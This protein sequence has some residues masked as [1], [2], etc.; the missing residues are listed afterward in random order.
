MN[1]AFTYLRQPLHLSTIGHSL[2]L[3]QQFCFSFRY[4]FLHP[5][6]II[7]ISIQTCCYPLIFSKTNKFSLN[8]SSTSLSIHFFSPSLHGKIL[9]KSDLFLAPTS[10]LVSLKCIP[11]KFISPSLGWNLRS[12]LLSFIKVTKSVHFAKSNAQF[13]FS[14][15]L[16]QSEALRSWWLSPIWNFLHLAS[17][18][19]HSLISL[20]TRFSLLCWLLPISLTSTCSSFPFSI[21]DP[22]L[23]SLNTPYLGNIIQPHGLKVPSICGSCWLSNWYL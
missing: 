5:S 23:F 22:R 16:D 3:H 20:A 17:R 18:T 15:L 21:L 12:T 14:I 11:L 9:W 19:P 2:T 7:S 10:L 4:Q 8:P 6:W 13:S 1:S